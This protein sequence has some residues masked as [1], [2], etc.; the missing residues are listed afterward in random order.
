MKLIQ[1]LGFHSERI[2]NLNLNILFFNPKFHVQTGTSLVSPEQ[3][4]NDATS[5]ARLECGPIPIPGKY[6][7]YLHIEG[8]AG[9]YLSLGGGSVTC[10]IYMWVTWHSF[11]KCAT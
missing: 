2:V 9:P 5:Q 1:A 3:I 10:R 7:E 11:I 6:S 4:I 8:D